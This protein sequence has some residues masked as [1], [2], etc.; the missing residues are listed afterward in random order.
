MD[1]QISI[2]SNIDYSMIENFVQYA[3]H[4]YENP[5]CVSVDEFQ[6]DLD[7]FAYLNKLFKRFYDKEDLN[8]RLILNH[9]IILYN[10][11][12]TESCTEMLFYK[13][14]QEY[15]HGLKTFLTYLSFMKEKISC[16][17]ILDSDLPID[18]T[19]VT[20]LRKI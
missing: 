8:T 11:F 19:I 10:V 14:K 18:E 2:W 4:H 7:K 5:H 15:W 1:L 9:I 20:E 17:N 12:E 6:K 13:T 3:M 16:V